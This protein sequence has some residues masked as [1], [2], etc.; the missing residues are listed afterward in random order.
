MNP[1]RDRNF[2]IPRLRGARRG[3]GGLVLTANVA[4]GEMLLLAPAKAKAKA[5]FET[6]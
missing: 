2:A 4:M 3:P 5:R 1:T 6:C